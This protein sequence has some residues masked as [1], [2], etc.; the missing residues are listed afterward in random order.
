MSFR[1]M[2]KNL[3]LSQRSVFGCSPSTNHTSMALDRATLRTCA[4]V[5]V[6]RVHLFP[7]FT[8]TLYIRGVSFRVSTVSV[9]LKRFVR[10]SYILFA[11]KMLNHEFPLLSS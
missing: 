7:F 10:R 9:A 8:N 4:K 3:L 5:T 6:R 11:L 2:E 1:V